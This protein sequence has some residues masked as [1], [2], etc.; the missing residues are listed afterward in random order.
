MESRYHSSLAAAAAPSTLSLQADPMD[1]PSSDDQDLPPSKTQRKRAMEDLQELGETLVALPLDRLK[2]LLDKQD[3]PDILRDA[4]LEAYRITSHGARKRHLQYIG[5]LMR[6]V[7]PEPL[8]LA[9]D[10]VNGASV[11]ENARLHRLEHLRETLLDD[12]QTLNHIATT[13]PGADLTHLRQL[14]RN[15]IKE[16]EQNKAPRNYRALFQALKELDDRSLT[17]LAP[18]GGEED[19][20]EI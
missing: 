20:E 6:E 3:L 14:R 1:K 7:D 13:Y 11:A 18:T 16:K 2:R 19:G 15:A 12:E 5:R 4:L 17:P 10:V 9:L 8:R